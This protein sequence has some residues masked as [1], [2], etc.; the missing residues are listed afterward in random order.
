[1]RA[2]CHSL[3]FKKRKTGDLSDF[4]P[5]GKG[6]LGFAAKIKNRGQ[7]LPPAAACCQG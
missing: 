6:F 1:V 7:I 4:L 5:F 2:R 3:W